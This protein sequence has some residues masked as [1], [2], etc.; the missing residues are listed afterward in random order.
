MTGPVLDAVLLSAV[1]A[2]VVGVLGA[3]VVLQ[4][5]RSRPAAAAVLAPVVVVLSL[6][7][8]VFASGRAMFLSE[9]DSATVLLVLLATVPV[10]LVIGL[11]VGRRIQRLAM[12][13]EVEARRR[14]LVA[15]V[16]HDLRSPLA[17]MQALIEA[18]EDGV[19]T[20]PGRDL[21]RLRGETLRLSAMVDDLLALSRL[22]SPSLRLERVPVSLTDLVSD[23]LASAEP[24]AAAVGV[25]VTGSAAGGVSAAVAPR[26][27]TRALDNLVD[28]ALRHTRAGGEVVVS[29]ARQ[30]GHALIDVRDA[31]GGIPEDELPRVFEAGWRGTAARTPGGSAGA[32]LGLAIVQ[33]VAEAHGGQATAANEGA[34]CRFRLRVPL[35]PA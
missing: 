30:D 19:A 15:W 28:N 25:R 5:A 24:R 33:G 27:L 31:C 22:Q 6:A 13:A 18:L 7:A 8:G 32:G 16:S 3:A 23:V 34:G 11:V 26:E 17:G 21:A 20:D 29:L 14:E 10:A 2:T 9:S 12:V 35:E 4:V 1:V